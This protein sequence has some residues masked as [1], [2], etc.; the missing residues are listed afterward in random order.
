MKT[1]AKLQR[2]VGYL[3][4][5]MLLGKV[6]KKSKVHGEGLCK[7]HFNIFQIFMIFKIFQT[8][9]GAKFS[10]LC[11]ATGICFCL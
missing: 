10:F 1:F 8:I 6:V 11:N 3:N 9:L 4:A 7:E 2:N 5:S